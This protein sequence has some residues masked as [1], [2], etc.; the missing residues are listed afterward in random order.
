MYQEEGQ[1]KE[2]QQSH[3]EDCGC[4]GHGHH[5]GHQGYDM[6]RERHPG[7]CVCGCH[8]HHGGMGFH[9]RFIS[10]EEI[11]AR[12]ENYLKQL[13]AEAKGVEERLAELKKT[14]ESQ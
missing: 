3:G 11:L 5:H 10:Q 1:N 4:G 2:R 14:K 6:R 12:L 8:Q 13:Q 9:R 7:G